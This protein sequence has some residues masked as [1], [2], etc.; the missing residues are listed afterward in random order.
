MLR[1]G[2]SSLSSRPRSDRRT[3]QPSEDR[4]AMIPAEEVNRGVKTATLRM[5][6]L[7]ITVTAGASPPLAGFQRGE[8][9]G[10]G[11]ATA[12]SAAEFSGIVSV[13]ELSDGRVLVA[14]RREAHLVVLDLARGTATSVG[15]QGPGPA[16]YLSIHP[17]FPLGGDSAFMADI[18]TRRWHIVAPVAGTVRLVSGSSPAFEVTTGVVVGADGSG[19]LLSRLPQRFQGNANRPDSVVLARVSLATGSVDTVGWLLPRPATILTDVDGDGRQRIRL[20]FRVLAPGEEAFLFQDGWVAVARLSPYRVDWRR[21]DGAWVRGT[22]LPFRET[23]VDQREKEAYRR[24]LR[25]RGGPAGYP[26]DGAP[27]ARTVPPF[28]DSPLQA[29]PRGDLIVRRTP[30]ADD[31]ATRYDVVDRTGRLARQIT[32]APNERIV[33]SGKHVVYVAVADDSGVERLR[34]HPWP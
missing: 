15:R 7:L 33:G 12:S 8:T 11:P 19:Y 18:T 17:V 32:L 20:F 31:E 21:P 6:C 5:A 22:P 30:T 34:R 2:G 23:V 1:E 13:V 16:E 24:R 27:W 25:D 28:E 14:D 29:S 3:A 26:P 10:L 4:V 9:L